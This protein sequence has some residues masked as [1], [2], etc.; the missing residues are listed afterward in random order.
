MLFWWMPCDA[1]VQFQLLGEP[2]TKFAPVAAAEIHHLQRM[3]PHAR[4]KLQSL[5]CLD[6]QDNRTVRLRVHGGVADMH[7]NT[8][9]VLFAWCSLALLLSQHVNS[10]SKHSAVAYAML[11]HYLSKAVMQPQAMARVIGLKVLHNSAG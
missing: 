7:M 1:A 10:M 5:S 4:C 11:L 6:L 8:L 3:C 9:T 2:L